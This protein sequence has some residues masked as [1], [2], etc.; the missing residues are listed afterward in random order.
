[1]VPAVDQFPLPISVLTHDAPKMLVLD[2][3][4]PAG[5]T[6]EP[7][8]LRLVPTAWPMVGATKTEL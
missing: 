4:S 3:I 8:K 6:P 1:M 2:C 5:S 7:V